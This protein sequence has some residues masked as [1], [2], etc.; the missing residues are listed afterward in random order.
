MLEALL[1]FSVVIAAWLTVRNHK[2][3]EQIK[4]LQQNVAPPIKPFQA[5]ESAHKAGQILQSIL[6]N[7]PGGV[8]LFDGNLQMIACNP[9]VIELLDFPNEMFTEKL[10]SFEELLRF[11]VARG[12]Y[13]ND[14]PETLI[15]ESLARARNPQPHRFERTR[16]NGVVLEI[17]GAPLPNG[18]FISI[19][20]DVTESRW[21]SE[22]FSYQ[23]HYLQSILD[24][25]P[26]GISVFDDKLHLRCWNSVL[27]EVLELPPEN[28]YDG[29]SFDE[30]LM[31]PATRGE[32]GPGDPKELVAARRELA[33]QFKPHRFERTR[34]N[35]RT[36][37]VEGNP[38]LLDGKVVGFV[39]S[40]TDITDR[41]HAEGVLQSKNTL[42]Q[43]L[44][45]NIPGGVTVFG[46][47]LHM[48]LYND[49]VLR[50][51]N[52]STELAAT[53]PHFTEVIRANAEKGEYG[54]VDVESK[55]AEMLKLAQNPQ[56]HTAERIRPDGTAIE[57]RGAPIEGGG[58]VTIYTDVTQRHQTEDALQRRTA[59]LQAILDQ[60]PQGVSV[61]DENLCLKHWNNKL[62]E[63]LDLPEEAVY[64]NVSFDDLIRI[65]AQKGEYG[66]G[67]V[68]EQVRSRRNLAERF[69]AHRIERTRPN[70]RSHLIEG[71]PMTVD[72][73]L[74]GFITTYTD[75]TERIQAEEELRSRNQTFRTLIDNI[76]GGVTLFNQQLQLVTSNDEYRRLLDFPDHLFEGTPTLERFFRFNAE[77]GEYGDC[78]IE[79]KVTELLSI[80]KRCEAHVFE[81]TRPNGTVLEIRGM[82]LL[83]G[84]FV[85][86][87]ADVTEH[88][89]AAE[90]IEKLAHEDPLTGLANRYT[91]EAR[92]DQS[93]ADMRRHK[94]QLALI[95]IDMDNFKAIN[96]SLGH[97]I[98]DDFLVEAAHRLMKCVRNNDIVARLG[99]DE[100]VVAIADLNHG[101][102]A[103]MMADEILH[104]LSQPMQIGSNNLELSA[105]LGISIFPHDGEDRGALMKNADIAMY[106]AKSEGRS[107]YRFYDIAMTEAVEERL[108]LEAMLKQ[109]L[110]QEEFFLHFQPQVA[111]SDLELV[112]FEA[113][114]R[115]QKPDG[116]LAPPLSFIPLAEETG[117][118]KPI[119]EWVLKTA[120][121][122]LQ[123]WRIHDQEN[124]V[125]IAVNLSAIQL[126]DEG[127][128]EQVKQVLSDTGLPA[129]LLELEVT[130]S[131]AM[132]NPELTIAILRSLKRLGIKLSIDD[133]GTGYSSLEYLK[134]LPIDTLKLDRTFVKDIENDP[135]DAAICTATT[136]LAHN[137]GLTVVA[138]GV[139]T[140]AQADFLHGLDCDYM[141]GFY[142]SRPLPEKEAQEFMLKT[143]NY[144][145]RTEK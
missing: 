85:T 33:L 60:L 2:L 82:P 114:L 104:E 123:A 80:A 105:S 3:K 100:F 115:W 55:V 64:E 128:V 53:H 133:F 17:Q 10:P 57:I 14:D 102:A 76:P 107:R 121:R 16:P 94:K 35:G 95:F 5:D 42:L 63:V 61:F 84:G 140:K 26:Q 70:G 37:L 47:D 4:H 32:Y 109:A 125:G 75:I 51:T 18:G 90:A 122:T 48:E 12:E 31:Y 44:V 41:K 93:L 144:E 71:Q 118:I 69:K 81:R 46:P 110:E 132:K 92:L 62:L 43:T 103:A 28:L 72:G 135:N 9:K 131:V 119:G 83:D 38:M 129:H 30:L 40:Y 127:I 138:E 124:S 99:G 58:F 23:A 7:I 25:L 141:Q 86:I 27:A 6:D 91:L 1:A 112:R 126:K 74:A 106:S 98:G 24:H 136:G 89:R 120:C 111:T 87:Y 36:H 68:D 65:P 137:L 29:V 13:G 56:H 50:L 54:D 66:P 139:E 73:A 117:L 15:N 97:A 130:E 20:S 101:Q 67:D 79:T 22:A 113:L 116:S 52:G 19:Y 96:D 143:E 21:A 134:L 77:R 108:R 142:F 8:T 45:D 11:N 34:P 59:Y 49:E 88:K 39:I 78:D 145:P